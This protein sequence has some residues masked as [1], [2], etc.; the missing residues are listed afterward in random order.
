MNHL[1]IIALGGSLGAAGRYLVS[2]NIQSPYSHFLPL[3]TLFVNV[4]GAFFVGFLFYLFENIIISR[5]IKSFITV[6]FLGAFTTFSTYSLE[7]INLFR[8]GEVKLG[9]TNLI[10]NNILC[11]IMVI[12]GIMTSKIILNIIR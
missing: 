7:T 2:K 5:E 8:D 9:I 11:L 1:F 6:G 10:L 3:G 12:A 4:S